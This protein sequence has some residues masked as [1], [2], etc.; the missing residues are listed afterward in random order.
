MELL[1]LPVVV[2]VNCD[3]RHCGR[4]REFEVQKLIGLLGADARLG[5]V[6]QR[7]RCSTCGR[8]PDGLVLCTV[9]GG[10]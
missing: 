8:R 5:D 1:T 6:T 9:R 10:S 4:H 7:L 3:P 2:S